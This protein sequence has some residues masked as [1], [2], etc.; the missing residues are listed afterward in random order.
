MPELD[1]TDRAIL[2]AVQRDGRV[3]IARLADS[4][5]LSETPC[6]RRLK[7]LESDGYIER[8]RA[9]LSRKALGFGVVAFVLVRFAVHDREV[10]NRFEREILAIERI[11]SCHNVS[12][13]A[14]YLLQVVAH[15]L[16]DYGTFLR[17]SL[18]V[19]PGV[20]SIE[21]ALSLREVKREAGLPVP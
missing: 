18:R 3:P 15:D 1:K 11:L 14:D 9:Q 21:S 8:Y 16:D 10:A 2:A 12:G 20:T 17:E 19:L 13:T 6:A 5:G 7:R 4:V